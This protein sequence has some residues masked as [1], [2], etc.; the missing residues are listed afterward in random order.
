MKTIHSKFQIRLTPIFL[1]LALTF[2]PLLAQADLNYLPPG[3][4]TAAT[5]LA[6]PPLLGSAEQNA[7]LDTVRKVYHAASSNDLTA[8]YSEKKFSVFNFTDSVGSYFVEAN[9]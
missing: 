3:Q 2:V 9:L 6:P 7:D 1:L 8:A 5:L 4:P